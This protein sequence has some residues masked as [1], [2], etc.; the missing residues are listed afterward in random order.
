MSNTES[1]SGPV[2][3][4]SAEPG[5]ATHPRKSLSAIVVG[6]AEQPRCTIYPPD[7][8]VPYRSTTWITAH[9]DAFISLDE[10]Q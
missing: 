1:E 10:C 8:A 2:W 6:P 9:G 5:P 4:G 3:N 7:V